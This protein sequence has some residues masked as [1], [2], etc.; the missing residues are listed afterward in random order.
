MIVA[1]HLTTLY[2]NMLEHNLCRFVFDP[3]LD[4]MKLYRPIAVMGSLVQN[5]RRLTSKMLEH[6]ILLP[7]Q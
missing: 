4:N 2:S 3:N 6:H 5:L 7:P 1:K